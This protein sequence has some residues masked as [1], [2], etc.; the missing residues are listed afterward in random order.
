MTTIKEDVL[1]GIEAALLRQEPRLT[2]VILALLGDG[3]ADGSVVSPGAADSAT[4]TAAVPRERGEQVLR[5]LN[6]I[7]YRLG[8]EVLFDG[9]PL[10]YLVSE[11]ER[12]TAA[13]PLPPQP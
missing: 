3:L 9:L 5:A 8:S 1:R 7:Q 11:W 6:A 4:I 12:F 10:C 2:T 13:P